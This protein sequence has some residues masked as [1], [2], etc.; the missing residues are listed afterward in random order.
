M[1]FKKRITK[2]YVKVY[3]AQDTGEKF[4]LIAINGAMKDTILSKFKETY[5][6][7]GDHLNSGGKASALPILTLLG[8]GTGALG[9]TAATTGTLFVATANPAT[10]MTLGSGV[11]SAVMGASGIVAQA[12]FIPVAGALMPVIAPLL[13]FQ[14]LSTII[15]LNQFKSIN[16]KLVSIEKTIKRVLQRNE[17]SFIGEVISACPR[18]EGIEKEFLIANQFS[19]DMIIRLALIEDKV[20]PIFERYKYL[21]EAQ[22]INANITGEDLRFKHTD[23]SMAI[24][25][26][27][28]DL[29]IDVLRVKLTIQENPGYIKECAK[30]LVEKVKRYQKLWTSIEKSP[31]RVAE[32]SQELLEVIEAMGWWEKNMPGFLGGKRKRK[33][34]DQKHVSDLF[35]ENSYEK[36]EGMVD[37][38]KKAKEIGEKLIVDKDPVS[39]LY[40]EDEN[41]KHSYY[42][43]DLVIN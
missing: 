1:F 8:G 5:Q 2:N 22:D 14:A 10:L 7:Q 26:S 43:S 19:T 11:G 20:N 38:A 29:R 41:G 21:Y 4:G 9:M 16:T 12:P 13:A 39:L 25:L 6:I 28:L 40:W 34:D 36:V 27:I 42:T 15:I 32:V 23:A 31:K 3:E 37:G 30:A 33:K 35:M 17:A 24:V 18:L